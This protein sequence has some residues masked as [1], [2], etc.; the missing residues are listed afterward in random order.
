MIFKK[1]FL[2]FALILLYFAFFSLIALILESFNE[3]ILFIFYGIAVF[4]FFFPWLV[5]ST[6]WVWFFKGEGT[7]MPMEELKKEILS[8]NSL[9]LPI[10]VT[11][12]KNKM[13]ITWKFVDAKW[14]EPFAK[15]GRK[16][17]YKLILKFKENK[18]EVVMIDVVGRLKWKVGIPDLKFSWSY[19]RGIDM[20]FSIGK[21]WGIKENFTLGKIFDF[22]FVPSEIKNPVMNT[23]LR[24]GWNVRMAMF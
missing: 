5:L 21:Q 19:F 17:A 22:K 13:V 7:P 10:Q 24:R 15:L 1:F 4:V 18:H 23:I 6:R 16:E 11:H 14:W 3:P 9:D 12:E 2:H 20:E 8:L